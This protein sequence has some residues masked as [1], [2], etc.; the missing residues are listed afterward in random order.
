MHLRSTIIVLGFALSACATAPALSQTPA[1]SSKNTAAPKT[2][3]QNELTKKPSEFSLVPISGLYDL[4]PGKAT[5]LVFN[6]DRGGNPVKDFLVAHEKLIHFIVVRNDLEDFQHLHPDLDA[7]TGTF[8]V[9]V[10]FPEN[11][12]YALFADFEPKD[13]EA[14]VLRTDVTI[15]T[16]TTPI[17]L[18]VDDGPQS[19]GAY[20]VTPSVESPLP[21]GADQMFIFG[22]S[23]NGKTVTDLQ[24]YLG[25]K[26]HAVILKE[27]TLDYFHA[28]PAD[29]GG[30]HGGMVMPGPGEVIFMATLTTP[31]RYRLFQQYRPEGNLITVA[32]TYEVFEPPSDVSA[33][34]GGD[35]NVPTQELSMEAFQWGYSP[36]VIKVKKGTRVTI[37]LTTRDVPHGF[38]LPDFDVSETILPGKTTTADF[39]ADKTGTFS[40]GCD[41]ACG[42]GHPKMAK[43][44]GTLIVE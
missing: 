10:T 29:Q 36:D 24:N 16:P 26:G 44:G 13:G 20:T 21:T 18:T 17:T 32:N 8:T 12:T 9:P 35:A 2:S 5:T 3:S 22:I 41:V 7:K 28:H 43:S 30:G 34:S 27:G 33:D 25:A 19:A 37:H 38:N 1:S 31:G 15:A 6:I 11:G 23:K 40:F 4:A 39:V 14:T 42:S